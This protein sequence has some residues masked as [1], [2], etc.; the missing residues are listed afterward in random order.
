M[1]GLLEGGE[2]V[3]FGRD[4]FLGHVAFESGVDDGSKALAWLNTLVPAR[5]YVLI[6]VRPSGVEAA[7]AVRAA[8]EAADIPFGMDFIGEGQVVRD[9]AAAKDDPE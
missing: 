9:G 3:G 5:D 6:L 8:I 2:F 4:E 7:L 1:D